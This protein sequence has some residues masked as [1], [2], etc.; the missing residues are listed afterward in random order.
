MKIHDNMSHQEALDIILHNNYAFHSLPESIRYNDNF[1]ISVLK[2]DD[3]MIDVITEK[4]KT[5]DVG[6]S[7]R[8][9]QFIEKLTN[10]GPLLLNVLNNSSGYILYYASDKLKDDKQFVLH[11]IS[12]CGNALQSASTRLKDDEDVVLAAV[13]NHGPA[14]S[15]AS[16]KIK[17]NKNIVLEAMKHGI[18]IYDYCISDELIDDR[19][20]ALIAL[21]KNGLAL[22]S[23]SYRLAQDKSITL[24]AVSQNG[25]A[26]KY[27][28]NMYK[29]DP[30]VVLMAIK[31]NKSSIEYASYNLLKDIGTNDP[32]KYLESILLYEKLKEETNNIE[33][34]NT[35]NMNATKKKI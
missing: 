32:Q 4:L 29:N 14:L 20:I 30:E 35:S 8:N 33:M 18:S 31:K 23:I 21:A 26:L 9:I 19:D 34:N 6:E 13:K 5:K 7:I 16:K 3:M 15:Y 12:S 28:E 24:L 2:K 17:G 25:E 22:E 27:A 10:N 11:F 1:I